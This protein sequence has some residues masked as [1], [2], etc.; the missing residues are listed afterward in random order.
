MFR[1][2]NNALLDTYQLK[3]L[4]A[5]LEAPLDAIQIHRN[6]SRLVLDVLNRTTFD[7]RHDNF[8]MREPYD[9]VVRCLG[10]RFNDSLFNE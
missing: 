10:F 6:G 7:A 8:A 4:D 9:R 1:G 3:S 5:M 2:V